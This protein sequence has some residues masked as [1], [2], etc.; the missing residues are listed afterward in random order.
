MAGSDKIPYV[1]LAPLT[2]FEGVD[3][4]LE[5]AAG[6][7]VRRPSKL[8]RNMLWEC[9]HP[10]PDN[11][12]GDFILECT[13]TKGPSKTN[14]FDACLRHLERAILTLRLFKKGIVGYNL[15]IIRHA[16]PRALPHGL[17][18]VPWTGACARVGQPN[19]TVDRHESKALKKFF[20]EFIGMDLGDLKLAAE[21]FNKSYEENVSPRDSIVDLMIALESLYLQG[22]NRELG[23]KLAI[24]MSH[25]LSTDPHTR[26]CIFDKVKK[27]YGLRSSIVH[28]GKKYPRIDGGVFLQI[29]EYARR[30]LILF[31]R[32][33]TLRNNLDKLVLGMT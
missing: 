1:V 28:G 22:E 25:V 14:F 13:I 5:L 6:Y 18:R 32:K 24:R 16:L 2:N 33:P 29:Q 30:S 11:A 20:S 17:S 4:P 3:D 31:L 27:A 19:Y 15:F 9:L 26:K 7:V 23:Y 10:E 12:W 8:E 21:Y